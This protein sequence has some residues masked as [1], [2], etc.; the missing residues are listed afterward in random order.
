M[1]SVIICHN[2][3]GLMRK[4]LLKQS[5]EETWC[6]LFCFRR[7]WF[8]SCIL[9]SPP[10]KKWLMRPRAHL[11]DCLW[12]AQCFHVWDLVSKTSTSCVSHGKRGI[13][14]SVCS[15]TYLHQCVMSFTQNS[16]KQNECTG[17][18]YKKIDRCEY[19]GV[20]R[21]WKKSSINDGSCFWFPFKCVFGGQHSVGC[22]FPVIWETTPR[23]FEL[24]W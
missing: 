24:Q 22:L 19:K 7:L 16:T 9:S 12:E 17:F 21:Y 20:Y 15:R 8:Y 11:L 5:R 18:L 13:A 1:P 23:G 4:K 2:C 6:S 3:L 14:S 10:R